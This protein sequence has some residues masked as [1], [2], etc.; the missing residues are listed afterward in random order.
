LRGSLYGLALLLCKL[1]LEPLLLSS[2]HLTDLLELPLKVGNPLLFLRRILRQ[3]G[4]ALG[5]FC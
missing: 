2:R 5:P 4:S 1:I 3:V